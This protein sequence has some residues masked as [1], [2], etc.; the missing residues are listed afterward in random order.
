[1]TESPAAQSVKTFKTLSGLGDAVFA[2]P[3]AAHFAKSQPVQVFTNYPEVFQFIEGVTAT[4]EAA[5]PENCVRLRYFTHP[6]HNYYA[7]YCKASGVP[8]LPF[9]LPWLPAAPLSEI[10]KTGGRQ[11]CLIK[12]PSAAHM[13]RNR[14]DFSITPDPMVIQRW[15]LDNRDRFFYIS[16]EHDTNTIKRRL[17]GIDHKIGASFTAAD[18][19]HCISRVDHVATQFGHLA[20]LA[21]AFGKPL[22]LFKPEQENRTGFLKHISPEMILVP[23]EY[24]PAAVEVI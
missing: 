19:I 24:A 16:F 10:F 5:I 22:T 13:H 6:G 17:V 18:Y 2:A 1:M 23:K 3:I 11:V 12:E 4:K 15:M 20:P 8:M 14:N 9:S 7:D 21:Q